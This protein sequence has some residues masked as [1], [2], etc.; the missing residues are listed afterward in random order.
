M[1]NSDTEV[2]PDEHLRL[3]NE[4]IQ[5][6]QADNDRLRATFGQAGTSGA[7]ISDAYASS[8][9]NDGGGS[10]GA[11]IANVSHRSERYIYLPRERKCP[12]F[13]GKDTD[14]LPVEEWVEEARRSL[15]VRHMSR[16]EQALF[17]YDLLDGEA[18][19]EKVP[20]FHRAK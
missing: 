13:S 19:N 15:E 1:S 11:G 10:S 18:K 7:G 2:N 5:Q 17:L 16:A 9:G 12:R 20:P 6:L 14:T 8:S 3:L 4:R